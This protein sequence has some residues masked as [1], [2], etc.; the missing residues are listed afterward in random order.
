MKKYFL[1]L[2]VAFIVAVFLTVGR[3]SAWTFS[4]AGSGECQPDGSYKITWVVDNSTESDALD[5]TASNRAV[6]PVGTS[7]PANSTEDF[8]ESADGT[9]A[10]SF[11]LTLKGNWDGD[12]TE[13]ERT[14]T[15][16]LDEPC[17][18][19]APVEPTPVA[20]PVTPPTPKV[21]P[22]PQVTKM[23]GK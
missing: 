9:Q 7:V 23:E 12:K 10:G 2:P 8:D 15:V 21:E 5:I 18:Q 16:T 20:P 19:P 6:V 13:R 1:I 17:D 4:L 3:A 22:E 14:A 11:T